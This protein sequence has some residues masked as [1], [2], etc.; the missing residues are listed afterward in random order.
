[1]ISHAQ[2]NKLTHSDLTQVKSPDM[3]I[4]INKLFINYFKLYPLS[5]SSQTMNNFYNFSEVNLNDFIEDRDVEVEVGDEYYSSEDDDMY[6]WSKTD[7][8]YTYL[9]HI[10]I[11][12]TYL[13]HVNA[14]NRTLIV[15]I[16]G[17]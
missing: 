13:M 3:I 5:L 4:Y 11:S 7:L 16:S 1:M 15:Y 9:T 6:Y 14:E 2:I 12:Y 17:V 10:Q 8:S